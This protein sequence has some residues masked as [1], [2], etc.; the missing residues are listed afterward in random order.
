M[1]QSHN[2][3]LTR[4]INNL[5]K[6][7]QIK[8]RVANLWNGTPLKYREALTKTTFSKNITSYLIASSSDK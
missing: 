6:K 8:Y 3:H 2:L 1:R 5:G 7:K 4:P